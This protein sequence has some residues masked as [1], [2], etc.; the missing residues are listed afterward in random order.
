VFQLAQDDTF[1][2]IAGLMTTILQELQH[3]V[4]SMDV[5]QL[6]IVTNDLDADKVTTQRDKLVHQLDYLLTRWELFLPGTAVAEAFEQV[7]WAEVDTDRIYFELKATPLTVS[8]MLHEKLWTEKTAILTSA[9]LTTDAKQSQGRFNYIQESLGLPEDVTTQVFPSPFDYERSSVL[10]LPEDLPDPNDI[11][12]AA[13]ATQA[14]A[15]ILAVSQG[16][17]FVLLTSYQNLKRFSEVLIPQLPYPCKVQGDMPRNRLVEWFKTTPH[18][19]LFATSTF[20][21]GIDVPGEALSCVIMDK[22]PFLPPD[23]PINAATI[24]HYKSTG[25][26]WFSDYMLPQAILRLKQGFGRLI[27][28]KSDRGIVAILDARIR[29]RG[30]GKVIIRSLPPVPVLSKIDSLKRHFE[31]WQLQNA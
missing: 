4:S 3:W 6:P 22:I 11:E 18:S 28:R 5:K 7:R 23:D 12:Y 31:Q 19:V 25:K 10:Y 24:E 17:A 30:Y 2:E 29:R 26:D 21:E 15:D 14:I 9:T 13:A 27:R 16:R 20:W 1:I 8:E